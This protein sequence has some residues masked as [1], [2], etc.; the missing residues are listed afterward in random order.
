METELVKVFHLHNSPFPRWLTDTTRFAESLLEANSIDDHFVI[1]NPVKVCMKT[2][3]LT[4]WFAVQGAQMRHV[5]V[6][7][8]G[9]IVICSWVLG[10]NGRLPAGTPLA[11]WGHMAVARPCNFFRQPRLK[12]AKTTHFCCAGF[13]EGV[14][15]HRS[16]CTSPCQDPCWSWGYSGRC[17]CSCCRRPGW[18]CTELPWKSHLPGILNLDW[19]EEEG[20]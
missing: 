9:D 15:L 7:L 19:I 10:A 16:C 17:C 12:T 11:P 6:G 2:M 3:A 18:S 14:V 5:K 20:K 8:D 13:C 4:L 1:C